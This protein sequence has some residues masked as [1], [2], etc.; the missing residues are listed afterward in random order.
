MTDDIGHLLHMK[1]F[2]CVA[3][4]LVDLFLYF[5]L[6]LLFAEFV[7]FTAIAEC[8]FFD[9]HPNMQSVVVKLFYDTVVNKKLTH[10]VQ[11]LHEALITV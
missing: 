3:C 1:Y 4:L 7:C 8:A 9:Y 6:K 10:R 11:L 2:A 5:I